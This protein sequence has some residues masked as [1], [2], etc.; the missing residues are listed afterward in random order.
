MRRRY[1]RVLKENLPLPDLVVIDGGRG[2]ISAAVDVLENE[3]GLYIPVCGL[4]KDEKHKTAQ[5]MMGEPPEV[6]QLPRD[7]QEFYLLQRIQDEVHRFA[8]TFHRE[9]RAKSM[10]V[11]TLDSIPG[12]GEKRRKALLKHFGSL[13]KIKE[14]AIEDFKPLGIGEKLAAQILQSLNGEAEDNSS[15]DASPEAEEAGQ[16]A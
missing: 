16:E 14:A 3:L 13:K 9:T 10:I 11:S 1:E 6:V 15:D 12:I 2:Q 5:L 7:S 4:V 8:I